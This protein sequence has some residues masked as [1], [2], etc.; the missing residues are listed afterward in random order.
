MSSASR[1]RVS[2]GISMRSSA[3]AGSAFSPAGGHV[4]LVLVPVPA[5]RAAACERAALSVTRAPAQRLL[6]VLVAGGGEHVRAERRVG[7][8]NLHRHVDDRSWKPSLAIEPPGLA[9]DEDRD[10][11]VLARL[12]QLGGSERRLGVGERPSRPS[13]RPRR[14]ARA[15]FSA[16]SAAATA[17]PMS[18]AASSTASA[19]RLR[20]RR[21]G[22]GPSSPRRARRPTASRAR[23]G[24]ACRPRPWPSS[25]V[26]SRGTG[27]RPCRRSRAALRA[28]V[29]EPVVLVARLADRVLGGAREIGGGLDVLG[30]GR[31]A[32]SATVIAVASCSRSAARA[33]A[34]AIARARL[35]GG[36]GQGGRDADQGGHILAVADAFGGARLVRVARLLVR[37]QRRDEVR[38]LELDGREIV[39]GDDDAG[40][41]VG[42]AEQVAG[43]AVG[44]AGC[45]HARR[46]SP[47]RTPSCMATPELVMRFMN[48][49]GR[50]AVE[51]GVVVA[52]LLEDAEDAGRASRGRACRWRWARSR[53]WSSAVV[54]VTVC[55]AERHDDHAAGP[56]AWAAWR[57]IFSPSSA[58][59]CAGLRRCATRRLRLPGGR[60]L[61]AA[62]G[63]E[64][65]LGCV[66]RTGNEKRRGR[67]RRATRPLPA[68]PGCDFLK[69]CKKAPVRI[70]SVSEGS[71]L[72]AGFNP[73]SSLA[74][75]LRATRA[76][77]RML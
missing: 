60:S 28:G 64:L 19:W 10:G 66:G 2:L 49:I 76:K 38:A 29:V 73:K 30:G 36:L 68:A 41:D 22:R 54:E 46:D 21:R 67:E 24:R 40:A 34:A 39:V 43:K 3:L 65:R 1:S 52:V 51:I 47:A 63:E 42:D 55:C 58:R 8:G 26:R 57:S 45:S 31:L 23:P 71:T 27:R 6:A 70:E 5:P 61:P 16:A 62:P 14:A 53:S 17:L 32:A 56:S 74:E 4:D 72:Y 7:V 35:V 25:R 77:E 44:Q 33:A 50:A 11:I 48:G 20:R 37:R 13:W 12:D 15:A 69:V 9:A 59:H 18:P 75:C